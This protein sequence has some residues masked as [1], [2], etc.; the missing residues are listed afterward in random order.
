MGAPRAVDV[1]GFAL[2]GT[3]LG[4]CTIAI[5]MG[6]R[7]VRDVID[8]TILIVLTVGLIAAW[9]ATSGARREAA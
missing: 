2:L 7:T 5:G 6:L 3:C 1:H 8:A 9:R 4:A